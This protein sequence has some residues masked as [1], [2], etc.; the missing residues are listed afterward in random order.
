MR[1]SYDG[2][3]A[4]VR[5]ALGEDPLGGEVFVFVNRRRTQ[6]KCLCFVGDGYCLWCNHR[7]SYYTSSGSIR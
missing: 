4:M 5:H 7:A 1:K 6:M 3:A 2:L